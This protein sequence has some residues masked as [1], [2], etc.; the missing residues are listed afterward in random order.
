RFQ[1]E[2]A[3]FLAARLKG[4]I[5][6]SSYLGLTG[7]NWANE[8]GYSR[9]SGVDAGFTLPVGFTLTTQTSVSADRDGIKGLNKERG[10]EKRLDLQHDSQHFEGHLTYLNRDSKFHLNT[11]YSGG[12]NN[13]KGLD[14]H[15]TYMRP[16]E[17]MGLH[18]AHFNFIFASYDDK[19][20]GML[21]Y[22]YFRHNTSIFYKFIGLWFANG[23]D[24]QW[25]KEKVE[26][27]TYDNWQAYISWIY[28]FESFENAGVRIKRGQSFRSETDVLEAWIRFKPL[29]FL[30]LDLFTNRVDFTG[31]QNEIGWPDQWVTNMKA[32]LDVT[33]NVYLRSFFQTN[34]TYGWSLLRDVNL[35][36]AWEFK[37]RNVLYVAYN[38]DEG[39]DLVAGKREKSRRLLVKTSFFLGI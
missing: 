34:D 5:F 32:R 2:E 33:Q 38:Y 8:E 6:G 14:G 31:R 35:L 12:R 15:I 11:G 16:L 37:R 26:G 13:V 27:R 29:G 28:N 21:N 39:W 30:S 25:S 9:A 18:D 4:D 3:N 19:D 7:V 23:L 20:T 24:A 10:W 36:L 17:L 22:D 1:D